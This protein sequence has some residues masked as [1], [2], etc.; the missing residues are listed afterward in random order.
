MTETTKYEAVGAAIFEIDPTAVPGDRRDSVACTGDDGSEER[1]AEQVAMARRIADALNGQEELL[2]ALD[3]IAGGWV[4][5][6]PSTDDPAAFQ[7]AMWE[8][9]QKH[10]RAAASTFRERRPWL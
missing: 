9:S 7:S 2:K 3:D 1:T 10:A 4:D 6:L 5:E 8:W